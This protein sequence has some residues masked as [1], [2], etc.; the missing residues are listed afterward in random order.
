VT[1]REG[2]RYV[3]ANREAE[4]I[5]LRESQRTHERDGVIR[6]CFDRVRRVPSRSRHA[7]VVKHHHWSVLSE[8]I[9]DSRIPMVHPPAKVLEKEK[10]DSRFLSKATV[11]EPNPAALDEASRSGDVSVVHAL[12]AGSDALWKC[13]N[14]SLVRSS[15]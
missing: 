8:S 5:N 2:L 7:S 6:H 11:G 10:G 4:D 14:R 3:A 1:Q 13:A 9:R 15:T 12:Q